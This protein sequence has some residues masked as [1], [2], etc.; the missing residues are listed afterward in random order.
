MPAATAVPEPPEEPPDMRA[1]SCGLRDGPSCAFS[2]V[3]S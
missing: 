3:K 1:G 2:P